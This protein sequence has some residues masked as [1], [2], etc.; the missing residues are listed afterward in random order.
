M[1]DQR[2]IELYE[3]K[4]ALNYLRRETADLKLPMV[5]HF[6]GA[7]MEALEKDHGPIS[8]PDS[9]NEALFPEAHN[10]F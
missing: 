5:S 10:D 2:D 1:S 7:S 4:L 9:L 6:L 3:I 8:V